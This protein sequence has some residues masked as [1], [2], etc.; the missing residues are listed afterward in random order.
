M[1]RDETRHRNRHTN[2]PERYV[3]IDLVLGPTSNL[4]KSNLN[5]LLGSYDACSSVYV[6]L[7]AYY[8]RVENKD[9][10]ILLGLTC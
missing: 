4:G 8:S 1:G 6:F 3:P 2:P 7:S 5:T 9:G 10:N